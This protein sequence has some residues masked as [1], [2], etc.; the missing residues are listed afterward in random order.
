M[1]ACPDAR[2]PAY[3]VAVGLARA[4]LLHSFRTAFYY[5]GEEPILSFGLRLAPERIGALAARPA[6]AVSS[7]DSAR[8]GPFGLEL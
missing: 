1:V 7:R 4:G 6:T 5:G 3:Q 8:P 2:P